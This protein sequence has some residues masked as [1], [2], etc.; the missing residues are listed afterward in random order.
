MRP[1]V[2]IALLGFGAQIL[3]CTAGPRE[4]DYLL[5]AWDAYKPLYMSSG[6]YVL[7]SERGRGEA[8]TEGQ[9]YALLRA[10][11]TCDRATFDRVLG[12]LDGHLLRP[13]GLYSWQWSPDAGGRVLDPNT[14]T[15]ADQEIAWALALAA[16]AFDDERYRDRAR[17]LLRAIRAHAS[18][19]VGNGWFPAAGNWAV[20]DRIVNLS[21]FLPYAYPDFDAVDPEGDW[22]AARETGYSLLER[23]MSRPSVR[24]PP[25]FMVVAPDGSIEPLPEGSTLGEDFS[26]DAMRLFW[27]VALD[28]ELHPSPRACEAPIPLAEIAHLY[29]RDGAIYARYSTR[30]ETRSDVESLSFYGSLLPA[31][32]ERDGALAARIRREK[33]S[34]SA[35][36][37]LLEEPDR[38]YDQNWVWFGLAAADGLIR[39]RST[40]PCRQN[41]PV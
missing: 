16:D 36:A 17:T 11:W 22:E 27:R 1:R 28:C 12:W 7:D 5:R 35:L 32:Q 4:P 10:V 6:R 20:G 41:A 30:G 15:D 34:P 23:V 14:A 33:L 29:A 21:Y 39:E 31:L 13:D 9:G 38:Y 37:D 18:I 19:T 26:F 8:I 24:L 25:D 40:R 3:A 2:A